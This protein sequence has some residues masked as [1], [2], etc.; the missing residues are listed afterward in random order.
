MA[1]PSNFD[2]VTIKG[3]YMNFTGEPIT[4]SISFL[5]TAQHIK[6][7]DTDTIILATKIETLVGADGTFSVVLPITNDPDVTPSFQY[8]VTETVAGVTRKYNIEI[9]VVLAGQI[10]DLADLVPVGALPVGT[11]ALT[12]AV[13]D[14]IYAFK[15]EGGGGPGGGEGGTPGESPQLRVSGGYIQWKLPSQL[16]WNNLI[17]TADLTGAPGSPGSP[18]TPGSPVQIQVAG[19]FIQW[20]LQSGSTWTNLVAL[21]SL[22][23]APGTPGSPGS[24]GSPGTPG[25]SIQLRVDSGFIQWKPTLGS[26]WNNLVDLASLKG[27]AGD[28]ATN[29]VTSVNEQTG[30]VTITAASIGAATATA[31]GALQTALTDLTTAVANRPAYVRCVTGSETRPS[32][33]YVIWVGGTTEPTNKQV[34][35]VWLKEV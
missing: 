30:P 10:I 29:L 28:P 5:P 13:A 25:D 34:N 32:V 19:G 6:H 21:T 8:S 14:L 27:P 12:R 24:P 33:N 4:G 35:D 20:K 11:T 22:Q 16:S 17:A 9:D 18:G 31:L 23:G 2:T 15:G 26:T 7:T 3:T 1:L